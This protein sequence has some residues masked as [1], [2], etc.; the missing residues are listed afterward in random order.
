MLVTQVVGGD[1]DKSRKPLY[2]VIKRLTLHLRPAR[3]H[4]RNNLSESGK[5]LES[6]GSAVT[7]AQRDDGRRDLWRSTPRRY[8]PHHW[9]MR[10]GH[11]GIFHRFTCIYASS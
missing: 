9:A 11:P 2:R 3:T 4:P 7:I 6:G 8:A 5:R 10:S 1:A